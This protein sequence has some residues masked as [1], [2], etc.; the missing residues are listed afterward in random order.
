[1]LIM[2]ECLQFYIIDCINGLNG[3]YYTFDN[4]LMKTEINTIV[5]AYR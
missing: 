3:I 2:F 1:M 5:R 4:I